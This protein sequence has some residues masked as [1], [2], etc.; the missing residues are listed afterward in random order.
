MHQS[1]SF[2]NICVGCV[3]GGG[4]GGVGRG[5]GQG[6]AFICSNTVYDKEIA[7]ILYYQHTCVFGYCLISRY[8][9]NCKY[10]SIL[11][12][13]FYTQST[14]ILQHLGDL[15]PDL[16]DLTHAWHI[17][18]QKLISKAHWKLTV[19]SLVCNILVPAITEILINTYWGN[20]SICN[21]DIYRE[22]IDGTTA[23]LAN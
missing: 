12:Y 18:F 21:D 8:Y 15:L 22:W 19:S 16:Y 7:I 13:W 23:Q 14:C 17:V 10:I 2:H 3:R 4:W 20:I 5:K 9:Y 6:S 11:K 1:T